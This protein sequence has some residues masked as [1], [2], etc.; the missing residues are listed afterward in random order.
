MVFQFKLQYVPSGEELA[1]VINAQC[2]AI[3]AGEIEIA[4]LFII[5]ISAWGN[6][7]LSNKWIIDLT[8]D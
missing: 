4:I 7:K 3:N 8:F 6:K 2:N 1:F 5:Y